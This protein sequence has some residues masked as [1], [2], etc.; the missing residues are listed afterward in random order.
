MKGNSDG[1]ILGTIQIFSRRDR[2]K[3]DTSVWIFGVPAKIEPY[4]STTQ[5]RNVTAL[6]YLCDT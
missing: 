1:R 4:T 6:A 3:P 2:G 5:L